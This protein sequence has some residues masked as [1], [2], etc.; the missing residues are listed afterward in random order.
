LLDRRSS[1]DGP[2][3]GQPKAGRPIR[4]VVVVTAGDN[5]TYDYYFAPRFA[6]HPGP[7]VERLD[8]MLKWRD[9]AARDWDDV[10]VILCRYVSREWVRVL[11]DNAERLAGTVLFLDDDM[12]ALA[13][14]AKSPLRYR[15][16]LRRLAIERWPSLMP[17]L[18]GIWV[19]TAA[20]ANRWRA[21]APRLLDPLADDVD[22]MARPK[23]APNFLIGL[24]ATG[25]H[26][27][28]QRWLAPV[29]RAVLAAETDVSFE[30][31]GDRRDAPRWRGDPRVRF[32]PSQDWPAYRADTA[33]HGRDILL[34]PLLP[35]EA[36]AARADVKRI[37]ASRC[38]AALLVSD[39]ALYR[40]SEE[41][42]ALDMVVPLD[43]AAWA[44]AVVALSHD[45][46]RRHALTAL[47]RK[48][49]VD[50]RREAAPLFVRADSM[51]D[52]AWRPN[53]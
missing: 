20:L 31:V 32:V 18:N 26:L 46:D 16:K 39:R 5:P 4:G 23:P 27:A 17:M 15:R 6:L 2:A 33:A 37:D 51:G 43:A 50:A 29:V 42:A 13:E 10:F 22:L 11:A 9:L 40:V 19:S 30:V 35:S 34:A 48:R 47:N 53:G 8:V 38:G 1:S 28:D 52:G 25:S 24:H 44:K 3:D 21:M 14:D 41:E 36:N 45:I 7:P 49:L 12:E